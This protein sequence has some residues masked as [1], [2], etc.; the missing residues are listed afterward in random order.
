MNSNSLQSTQ[1]GA[2]LVLGL[3][4]LTIMSLITVSG[5]NAAIVNEKISANQQF[6]EVAFQSADSAG[7]FALEQDA[8]VNATLSQLE[9]PEPT[10]PTYDVGTIG[11]DDTNVNVEMRARRSFLPGNSV[12]LGGSFSFYTIETTADATAVAT[13]D[14]PSQI[15]KVIVKAFSR[16]GA[17]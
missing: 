16:A 10:W 5:M 15:N 13:A 2:V 8:W 17:G 3:L 12:R 14:G 7:N 9:V 6:V 11:G 1:Q 4:I